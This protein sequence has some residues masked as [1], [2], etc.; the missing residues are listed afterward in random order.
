MKI[1]L[2]FLLGLLLGLASIQTLSAEEISM[3][4]SAFKTI[5]GNIKRERGGQLIV[6][7]FREDGYPKIHDKAISQF[8]F[9]PTASTLE[10]EIKVPSQG[11]FALKVLHDENR[12]GKVTKNWTGI[13]PRDGMGFSSG[14]RIRL[15][16]PIFAKSQITH[17][18][19]PHKIVMQ[20]F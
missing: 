1:L 2:Y 3:T 20:Y 8:V 18:Q 12:D 19:Q 16:P 17:E 6:F 4:N 7:V 15:S 5:I 10:V 14:Q 11:H 13:I 9:E